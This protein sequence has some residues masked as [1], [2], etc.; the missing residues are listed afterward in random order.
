MA[1]VGSGLHRDAGGQEVKVYIVWQTCG[2]YSDRSEGV[3]GD[4]VYP[5]KELAVAAAK[6]R[7][8]EQNLVEEPEGNE[9]APVAIGPYGQYGGPAEWLQILS[10]NM[11]GLFVPDEPLSPDAAQAMYGPGEPCP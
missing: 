11:L 1:L 6:A 2:E 7:A 3:L 10:L 5:T 9:W 8:S 4:A